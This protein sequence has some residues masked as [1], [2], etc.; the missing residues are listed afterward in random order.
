MNKPTDLPFPGRAYLRQLLE[1]VVGYFP[2]SYHQREPGADRD[3]ALQQVLDLRRKP[4]KAALVNEWANRIYTLGDRLHVYGL[5]T[6]LNALHPESEAEEE[7]LGVLRSACQL[8]WG[9]EVVRRA[10]RPV[11]TPSPPDLGERTR[12]AEALTEEGRIHAKL[13]DWLLYDRSTFARILQAIEQLVG[14]LIGAND[15]QPA[16]S[17]G[18]SPATSCSG[19]AAGDAVD[20]TGH[21][22]PVPSAASHTAPADSAAPRERLPGPEPYRTHDEK[23][24]ELNKKTY[25]LLKVRLP[26]P[27]AVALLEQA[28][29]VL[30]PDQGHIF[31]HIWDKKTASYDALLQIPGAFS[32]GG[33]T[34]EAVTKKL[35]DMK[36]RLEEQNLPVGYITISR[37]KRRITTTPPAN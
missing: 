13:M 19:H 1:G 25:E 2:E 30:T 35:Q 28:L 3:Q 26:E 31:K 21:G 34:D 33:V 15:S 37:A 9:K 8:A 36:R 11:G 23:A 22:V 20:A 17:A 7:A 29:S 32:S 27:G 10:Q 16:R 14:G 6:Q 12:A 18:R 5:D 4:N 24:Y